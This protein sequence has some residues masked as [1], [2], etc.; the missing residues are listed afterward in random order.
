MWNPELSVPKVQ[1][2]GGSIMVWFG[3]VPFLFSVQAIGFDR[4]HH[5]YQKYIDYLKKILKASPSKL[6]LQKYILQHDRDLKN[7]AK[8]PQRWL[9]DNGIDLLKWVEQSSDTSLMENVWSELDRRMNQHHPTNKTELWQFFQ[10][11]WENIVTSFTKLLVAS[12]PARFKSVLKQNG[13]STK[14]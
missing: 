13:G 12:L 1:D 2:D 10:N 11:E 4:R 9:H 6:R 3:T 7:T 8:S 5:G 14:Y